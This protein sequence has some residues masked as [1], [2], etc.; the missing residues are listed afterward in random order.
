M[1]GQR[2]RKSGLRSTLLGRDRS[3]GGGGL[4]EQD[5]KGYRISARSKMPSV[6]VPADSLADYLPLAPPDWRSVQ[7]IDDPALIILKESKDEDGR[8]AAIPY[9]ETARTNR[10]AG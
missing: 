3:L 9:R 1:A 7:Q 5:R 4:I 8:A 10:L 2:P 6:I